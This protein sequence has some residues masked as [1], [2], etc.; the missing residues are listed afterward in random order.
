MS[1]PTYTHE[2]CIS[3]YSAACAATEVQNRS[4]VAY[5]RELEGYGVGAIAG[6]GELSDSV[7]DRGDDLEAL[8]AGGLT[9]RDA[10][11]YKRRGEL[12]G[13]PRELGDPWRT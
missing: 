12:A 1:L 6:S 5:L 2:V 3:R 4:D 13:R 9:V 11:G 10:A 8:L 7:R